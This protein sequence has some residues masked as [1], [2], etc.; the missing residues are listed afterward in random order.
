M[1]LLDSTVI[2]VLLRYSEFE[3]K[4]KDCILKGLYCKTLI[5]L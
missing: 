3:K 1:T 5:F 4:E 2:C